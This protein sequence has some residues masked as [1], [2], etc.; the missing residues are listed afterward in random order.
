MKIAVYQP[1]ISYYVGGGEVVPLQMAK[2]FS[3]HKHDVTIV[4]S[5]HP[6]GNSDYFGSFLKANSN[7]KT[8]Y[9]ELPKTLKWIY[10]EKPGTSQLR[11]DYEAVHVGRLVKQGFP[12]SL[13]ASAD[14]ANP[15]LLPGRVSFT[16]VSD[17][18]FCQR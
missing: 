15:L 9:L 1:R 6:E 7:I 11:W 17:Y 2:Y 5:H 10:E 4:T 13:K 3:K 12:P 14:T 18:L 8:L 16:F